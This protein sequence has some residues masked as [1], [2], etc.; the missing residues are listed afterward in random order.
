MSS[1][2]A[3]TSNQAP[4]GGP[5]AA[6]LSASG[7]G[8][9]H[10]QRQEFSQNQPYGHGYGT[11]EQSPPYHSGPD[12]AAAASGAGPAGI[13]PQPSPAALAR[14]A[15]PSLP[16]A[17]VETYKTEMCTLFR[18]LAHCPFGDACHYAH[19]VEEIRPRVFGPRYKTELCQ[20]YH[21]ARMCRFGTRCRFIHD[22]VRAKKNDNE[23]WLLC[24]SERLAKLEKVETEV[25]FYLYIHLQSSELEIRVCSCL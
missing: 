18:D 7:H 19:G 24:P 6:L 2:I 13:A 17:V 21:L 14:A 8:Q 11:H 5:D 9:P 20:N 23:Y 16:P 10:A 25:C 22:E 4:L 12:T 15:H 1:Q 3:S